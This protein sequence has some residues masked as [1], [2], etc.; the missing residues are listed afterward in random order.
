MGRMIFIFS[1]MF[2]LSS[3]YNTGS[4][5][6]NFL[7]NTITEPLQ[8]GVLDALSGKHQNSNMTDRDTRHL[9]DYTI[10]NNLKKKTNLTNSTKWTR[11]AK[12]RNLR[13]NN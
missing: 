12:R 5:G 13:C 10:C 6:G 3:C 7:A 8:T 9:S 11:E 2:Y 4:L 1:T